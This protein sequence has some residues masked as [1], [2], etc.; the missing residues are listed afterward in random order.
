MLIQNANVF[1]PDGQFHRLD[2]RFE[3]S[4]AATGSFSG[5]EGFDAGGLYLLPGLIDIHT[6]GAMDGDFSDGRAQDLPRMARYYAAHGV[7][8]FLATTMTLP[9]GTLCEAARS[10]AAFTP[11]PGEAE[12]AGLH[13]EGP[14]L[15]YAKR[16]AQ[17]AAYLHA[18][19]MAAF[20]RIFD[21]AGGRARL[22]TVAPEEE[23]A[24]AFIE[25]ASQICAVSLG[26]TSAG[27]ESARAAF[28]AGASQLTH[29]YNAMPG[30]HHREPG[31]IGAAA[32]MGA[33]AELICDGY[34]VHPSAVRA[35]FA[36]FPGRVVLVSDSLRCAGMPEGDYELGGQPITLQNGFC[37]LKGSDTI[38][39]SVISV[40]DALQNAVRFGVPLETAAA[41][42]TH[43]PAAAA[44]LADRGR[45]AAGLRADFVLL[46]KEL[47]IHSVYIGGKAAAR[48]GARQP[49][50]NRIQ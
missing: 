13:L 29:L 14:F 4:I 9:I 24:L 15:C 17:N 32:D 49:W 20:G 22:V 30:L 3:G 28:A 45:I 48:C 38:A 34:H 39:G 36:L 50:T 21:A 19:D 44:R 41:A 31:P 43:N 8:S 1:M 11:A 18:P 2:V 10:I 37:T 6:H 40:H 33:Y 23:G 5:E 42:A 12:C 35:A 7:T 47:N 46:D 16:G 26:H 25:A 27:Y